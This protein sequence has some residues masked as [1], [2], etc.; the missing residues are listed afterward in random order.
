M[1]TLPLP[2]IQPLE[3]FIKVDNKAFNQEIALEAS[4]PEEV[5]VGRRSFEPLS[6]S[7]RKHRADSVGSMD[8]MNSNRASIGS[9]ERNISDPFIDDSISVK[10]LTGVE[11]SQASHDSAS[12]NTM[13]LDVTS[14]DMQ[15]LLLSEH[16]EGVRESGQPEPHSTP[17]EAPA[18]EMEQRSGIP[19]LMSKSSATAA[20]GDKSSS[21]KMDI[22]DN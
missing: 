11:P 19:S 4:E 6:P 8:S 2:L 5:P 14:E 12:S 16:M 1:E 3:R 10:V 7:K 18:P 22:P 15:P 21:L 17:L 9:E 13:D 20:N